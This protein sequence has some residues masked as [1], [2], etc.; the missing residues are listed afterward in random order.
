MQTAERRSRPRRSTRLHRFPHLEAPSRA[1][2]ESRSSQQLL[3]LL[4][5]YL[6]GFVRIE[7]RGT[8]AL[9]IAARVEADAE[10]ALKI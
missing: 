4:E 7:P 6:H 9:T 1:G 3:R 8:G 10:P 2:L 5:K